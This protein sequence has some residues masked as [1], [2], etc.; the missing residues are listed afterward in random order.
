MAD[1]RPLKDKIIHRWHIWVGAWLD[2]FS[3]IVRIL[4][5]TAYL[6]AWDYKYF[7][8]YSKREL[9]KHLD[10]LD[11]QKKEKEK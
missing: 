1:N 9:K 2:I 4:T 11:H 5:F 6:P 7:F 10:H 3:S 8:W